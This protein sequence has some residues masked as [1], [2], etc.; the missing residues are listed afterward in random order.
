MIFSL[1]V[2][3]YV[4]IKRISNCELWS[5]KF[6]NHWF[7]VEIKGCQEKPNK[8]PCQTK[9][10]VLQIIIPCLYISSAHLALLSRWVHTFL[11]AHRFLLFNTVLLAM[12]G[13]WAFEIW[14]VLTDMS[15]KCKMHTRFWRHSMKKD[16]KISY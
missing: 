1:C 4:Y 14:L 16:H 12:Y 9:P 11:T 6:E 15:C 5:I 3:A 8:K 2:C 10:C 7:K 13:Y